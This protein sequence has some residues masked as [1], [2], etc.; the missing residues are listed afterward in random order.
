MRLPYI[1]MQTIGFC[2]AILLVWSLNGVMIAVGPSELERVGFTGWSAMVVFLSIATGAIF[3]PLARKIGSRKS[4]T[5]EYILLGFGFVLLLAGVA[6][7]SLNMVLVSAALAGA[8]GFGLIYQGGLAAVI[9]S[10]GE[11]SAR[12]VSGYFLFAYIGLGLPSIVIGY[13]AE[14]FGVF[15]ALIGVGGALITIAAVAVVL[16]IGS[17]SP[18]PAKAGE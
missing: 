12:A 8:T 1:S 13:L 7:Q 14:I 10:S 15:I 18:V 11:H 16:G 3:Q 4:L 2:V 5:W 9:A 17:N 6:V